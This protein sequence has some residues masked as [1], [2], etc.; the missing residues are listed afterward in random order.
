MIEL[1]EQEGHIVLQII[2]NSRFTPNEWEVSVK[3]IVMKL[4]EPN[5]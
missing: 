5:L 4:Q 2:M 1:T 3:P